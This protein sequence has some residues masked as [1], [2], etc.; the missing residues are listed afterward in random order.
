MH[1]FSKVTLRMQQPILSANESSD[2]TSVRTAQLFNELH[3]N[4]IRH[5]DRLFGYLMI[6][7]WIASV[8]AAALISP[9][10]WQGT[11]SQIHLHVYAALILG[12]IIIV[13]P[14][15]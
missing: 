9:R 11:Q 7:Q 5:T 12:G 15:F 4:I 14:V 8:A 1:G 10:T 13:V 2:I 6:C 3:Q